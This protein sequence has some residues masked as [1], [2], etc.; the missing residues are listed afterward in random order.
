MANNDHT[1]S[2]ASLLTRS[3]S[4]MSKSSQVSYS[5]S[6]TPRNVIREP[7]PPPKRASASARRWG[8]RQLDTA[9]I[10]EALADDVSGWDPGPIGESFHQKTIPNPSVFDRGAECVVKYG[11]R[12][13]KFSKITP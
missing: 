13:L 7:W 9:D 1:V 12:T 8:K 2:T 10:V 4:V 5:P 6:M 3:T 11:A